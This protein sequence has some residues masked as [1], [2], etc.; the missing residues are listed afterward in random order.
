M[1][2]RSSAFVRSFLAQFASVLLLAAFENY[3][4][5]QW[6][7]VFRALGELSVLYVYV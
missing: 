1:K 7:F 3:A 4:Y 2:S 6:D 5:Y